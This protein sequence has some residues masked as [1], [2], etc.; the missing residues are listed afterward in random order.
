MFFAFLNKPRTSYRRA[1]FIIYFSIFIFALI[2]RLGLD[3]L[4][5]AKFGPHATAEKEIWYYY[6]ILN[7]TFQL[8]RLDPT[9]WILESVKLLP[10]K[11]WFYGIVFTAAI[12]SSLTAVLVSFLGVKTLG[13]RIGIWAGLVYAFLAGPLGESMANFTHDLVQ[14]PIIVALFLVTLSIIKNRGWKR[15]MHICVFLILTYIGLAVGPLIILALFISLLYMA[16]SAVGEAKRTFFFCLILLSLFL[17]RLLFLNNIT[18]LLNHFSSS[19]RGIDLLSQIQ[20]GSRDLMPIGNESLLIRIGIWLAL[21]LCGL[22]FNFKA[23]EPFA[24]LIFSVGIILAFGFARVVRIADIGCALIAASALNYPWLEK[25]SFWIISIF[26]VLTALFCYAKRKPDCREVEY[27]TF[28]W[29]K[30]HLKRQD[31]VLIPWSD[32]YFLKA[33]SG[34]EPSSTPE[35]IDFSLHKIYWASIDDAYRILKANRIKF[36]QVSNRYFGVVAFNPETDEFNYTGD[37]SLLYRP[38][39][40]GIIKFSQLKNTLLFKLMDEPAELRDFQLVYEARDRATFVRLRVYL[41]K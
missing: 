11:F 39:E 13:A 2:G 1:G 37:G 21:V 32:G 40:M 23:R 16:L 36:V 8:S 35:H 4:F 25:R 34:L 24:L 27:Q 9:Y 20:A 31:K 30:Q 7:H 5:F 26:C 28:L 6:G 15:F 29:M 33:V 17:V 19:V 41:V 22:A 3:F 12:L 10:D 14:L 18:Q 38:E